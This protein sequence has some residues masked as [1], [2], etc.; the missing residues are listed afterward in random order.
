MHYDVEFVKLGQHIHFEL[1]CPFS[2]LPDPFDVVVDVFIV[3]NEELVR[4][5]ILLYEVGCLF[6]QSLMLT[7]V[8]PKLV[9][10][11]PEETIS[12]TLNLLQLQPIR[13]ELLLKLDQIIIVD[14]LVLHLPQTSEFTLG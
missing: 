11:R 2:I 12:V 9:S 4:L 13:P 7:L 5:L 10:N 1:T 14:V 3:F 8:S 6:S